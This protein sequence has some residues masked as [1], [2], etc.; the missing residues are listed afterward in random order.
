MNL[1]SNG[2]YHY[3]SK[4]YTVALFNTKSGKQF[5]AYKGKEW[6]GFFKTEQEA[7]DKCRERAKQ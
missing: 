1:G 4:G 6:L 7:Q 2:V 5:G 3:A